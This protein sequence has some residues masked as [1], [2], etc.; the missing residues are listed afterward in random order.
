MLHDAITMLPKSRK[1]RTTNASSV[2]AD[3]EI[4][5]DSVLLCFL[6]RIHSGTA[7]YTVNDDHTYKIN[8]PAGNLVSAYEAPGYALL[9]E[10]AKAGPDHNQAALI[11]AV[12]RTSISVSSWANRSYNYMQFRT[13]S[14]GIEIGSAS[15]GQPG[16]CQYN[17]L[18]AFRIGWSGER[19]Q[20]E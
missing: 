7:S 18:L 1:N 10:A 2:P 20:P 16:K 12:S 4:S 3:I 19:L 6:S 9:I 5:E 8:D 11:T 17:R 15:V 14:G 13:S